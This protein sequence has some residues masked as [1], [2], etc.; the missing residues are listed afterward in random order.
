MG[1]A[2]V[3]QDESCIKV[4]VRPM[5]VS[6]H[7]SSQRMTDLAKAFFATP[8]QIL[9][10]SVATTVGQVDTFTPS[11]IVLQSIQPWTAAF[12]NLVWFRCTFHF[13]I[14]IAATPFHSGVMRAVWQPTSVVNSGT[15]F[16]RSFNR[17]GIFTLPGIT[18][19][20]QDTTQVQ[21]TVPWTS[22]IP[23][24]SIRNSAS[25]TWADPGIFRLWNLTD[26]TPPAGT[27]S[28]TYT[29][30]MHMTDCEALGPD[31]ESFS[32]VQPQMGV[33]EDLRE[34]KAISQTL[35][36]A[37]KFATTLGGIPVMP[38]VIGS[39]GWLL[40]RMAKSVAYLGF[41][42]PIANSPLMRMYPSRQIY[43]TNASGEDPAGNLSLLHDSAVPI[44]PA[45]GTR[46]DEQSVSY[47]AKCPGLINDFTVSTQTAGTLI[48]AC[49]L[50]PTSL[51]FQT[52]RL[53]LPLKEFAATMNTAP[54]PAIMASP[55]CGVSTLASYWKSSFKFDFYISKTRFHTGRIAFVY[56]PATID[57]ADN[58]IRGVTNYSFPPYASTYMLAR[59]IIDLRET[60]TFTMEV[61]YI[62]I[63]PMCTQTTPMG[64]LC[65]YVVDPVRAPTTVGQSVR[66]LVAA[67]CPTLE[68][69]GVTG[70]TLNP[71]FSTVN[72]V[73]QFG[74]EEDQ[75]PE[76]PRRSP[77]SRWKPP[78]EVFQE[79]EDDNDARFL[80]EEEKEIIRSL[81][82]MGVKPDLPVPIRYTP[83]MNDCIADT[84]EEIKSLGAL[85]RRTV[86]RSFAAGATPPSPFDQ[87]MPVYLPST[88]APT[89]LGVR[90]VDLHD[91]VRSAY[92]YE[93]GGM[94]VQIGAG[95]GQNVARIVHQTFV[96]TVATEIDRL[97][98]NPGDSS[99]LTEGVNTRPLVRAYVPRYSP[100]ALYKASN[101]P[102][103]TNIASSSRE[104]GRIPPTTTSTFGVDSG[105]GEAFVYGR[106]CADDH[107]FQFFVGWPPLV[108]GDFTAPAP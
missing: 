97:T 101:G 70:T 50:T 65:A 91:F 2:L 8:R 25:A 85:T 54:F 48:Y 41:S 84:G 58:Q 34:S 104:V 28:P 57:G 37:G 24:M 22:N 60:T 23:F 59:D 11:A 35:A 42:K 68:L 105:A 16:P 52:N 71:T 3:F 63:N 83:Q 10:G 106:A 102:A 1:N 82:D 43:A 6:E 32:A 7:N 40:S 53:N 18:F 108:R 56:V 74:E 17:Q 36:A 100:Y 29:V 33:L 81:E 107:T 20:L 88:A 61:P 49:A 55:A 31:P 62:N 90:L 95:A 51:F 12:A 76:T 94:I 99:N 66:V 21:M 44:E 96:S 38:S 98:F 93:R 15:S 87:N 75:P 19:N 78:P 89:S 4:R 67:S 47:I 86:F 103:V 73:A 77:F 69:S 14:N 79:P 80:T 26:V 30:F 13:T 72:F 9:A 64:Y 45:S 39:A 5:P 46:V 27:T 92:L